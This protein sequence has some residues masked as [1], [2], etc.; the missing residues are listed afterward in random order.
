MLVSKYEEIYVYSNI[1]MQMKITYFWDTDCVT[2][3]AQI[4]CMCYCLNS[5]FIVL[6]NK[7]YSDEW[8]NREDNEFMRFTVSVRNSLASLWL[9][10]ACVFMG[11]LLASYL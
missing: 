7:N 3:A 4:L 10:A 11:S 2:Q 9:Q 6:R 8:W 5:D 1:V